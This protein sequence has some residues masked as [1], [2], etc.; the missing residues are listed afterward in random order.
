VRQDRSVWAG[1]AALRASLRHHFVAW[2]GLDLT[3]DDGVVTANGF[4]RPQLLDLALGQVVE[5]V[6]QVV[7][8]LCAGVVVETERLAPE[9]VN[10]QRVTPRSEW[11]KHSDCTAAT[12]NRRK[13]TMGGWC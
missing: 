2:D 3:G 5:A 10:G 11:M 6:K 7:G 4:L 13:T 9:F 8:E 12:P 1:S